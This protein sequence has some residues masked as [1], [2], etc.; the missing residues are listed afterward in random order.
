MKGLAV[1]ANVFRQFQL[2]LDK[3]PGIDY[4]NGKLRISYTKPSKD[5]VPDPMAQTELPLH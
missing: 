4:H 5:A 2:E 1:Y 3:K